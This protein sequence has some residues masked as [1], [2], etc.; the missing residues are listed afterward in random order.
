MKTDIEKAYEIIKNISY[1]NTYLTAIAAALKAERDSLPESV[2]ACIELAYQ[3]TC[4]VTAEAD[5]CD[6]ARDELKCW[7]R[8]DDTGSGEG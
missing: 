2:I 1:Q 8:G 7:Q 3:N 6:M 4:G 5:F